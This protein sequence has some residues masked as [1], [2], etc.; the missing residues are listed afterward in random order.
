LPRGTQIG[1]WWTIVQEL[2]ASRLG[3][4]A[5]TL[6]QRHGWNA[7]TVYRDLRG[8]EDAGLPITSLNGRW[9]LV[10]GS[11][12]RAMPFPIS[13]GERL[14]LG[15]ARTL[16]T[17]LDGTPVARDFEK[18][19]ERLAGSQA[20]RAARQG[21]LFRRIRPLLSAPS[22]LAIDYA[23]HR[24]VVETLC[25]ASERQRTVRAVY[26]AE[27]RREQ[28][29]R[30]IDPYHVHWDPRLE[31][32]YVFGWCHLRR[33]V[34]TFAAHRFRR[35][36]ATKNEFELPATFSPEKYLRGAFRIWRS[37]NAVRVRLGIDASDA[38]W[39]GE[40]RW[41]ASQKV[42]RLAGGGCEIELTVADTT[43]LKRFILQLGAAVEVLEPA[44]LRRE[45]AAEHAAAAKRGRR[46]AQES[47]S[48]DDSGVRESGER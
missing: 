5:E 38:G 35:V 14:A 11:Q 29:R 45:I 25:V 48:F 9:R 13:L 41:H 10:E 21:E 4:P 17:P 6:A 34:R 42:R 32:L 1:R 43:E 46:S 39:V 40:R 23:E 16:I 7:R 44:R 3:L 2:Q 31:A 47:L 18:L 24:A 12:Q 8:L 19:Y 36:T 22:R 28:T 37:E 26:Y 27:S 33:D 30:D 15:F 20:P